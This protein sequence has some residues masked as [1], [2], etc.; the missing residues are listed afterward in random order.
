M[1]D[2]RP[3]RAA[4]FRGV[5]G[6]ELRHGWR[7]RS[8]L[9]LV[10]VVPLLLAGITTAAFARL[11]SAGAVTV[12][13]VDHDG[14][15]AAQTLVREILPELTV[16]GRGLVTTELYLT[17]AEAESDT[18][19]GELAAA[20]VIPG[21]FAAGLREGHPPV[22]RL[23]TGGDGS[24]GAPVTKAVLQGFAAQTGAVSLAMETATT[25]PGARKGDQR[26][27]AAAGELRSPVVIENVSAAPRTLRPAGYFAPAMLVLALFFC[28]QIAAR[29]LVAERARRTLA[30]M[31]VAAAPGWRVLLAKYTAA[32]LTGVTAAAVLLGTFSAFGTRFGD[33]A[34]LAVLVLLAALA[35]I[36]VSS[37]VV[38]VAR[39]EQHAGALGTTVAFVL[40]VLGGSFVPP[41]RLSPGLQNLALATPNG[42]AARG[43]SDLAGAGAHPWSAL[44]GPLLALGCIAVLTGG[45]TAVLAR[46][47]VRRA[48]V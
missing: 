11:D 4:V 36:G 23:L 16:D 25:G 17:D 19:D 8:V 35:M 26:L 45:A 3:P 24:I 40:A 33:P 15:S 39:T 48:H 30:R 5:L 20:I 9:I 28:G 38:L 47:T 7:D 42:W 21:G 43:F 41:S 14:G 6:K 34:A 2:V 1:S 29:G 13:V 37:L 18:R 44:G 32:L 46:R 27:A 12:G 10:F 31:V 22:L